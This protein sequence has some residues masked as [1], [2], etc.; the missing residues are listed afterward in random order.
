MSPIEKLMPRISKPVRLKTR[1]P[2]CGTKMVR[3]STESRIDAECPGCKAVQV[4]E[5]VTTLEEAMHGKD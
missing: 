2:N 5:W 4:M 3:R 1:C